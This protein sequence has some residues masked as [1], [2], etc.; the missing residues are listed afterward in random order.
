[1]A[2]RAA[3]GITRQLEVAGR[4]L[5]GCLGQEPPPILF[6]P[7][8]IQVR[9]PCLLGQ[10]TRPKSGLFTVDLLAQL[11]RLNPGCPLNT[12]GCGSC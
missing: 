8:L 5:S 7:V 3:T 10:A 4:N 9:L 6:R 1:M 11:R 12:A 2:N